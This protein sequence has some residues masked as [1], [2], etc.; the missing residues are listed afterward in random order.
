[1]NKENI[2][3]LAGIIERAELPELK[4]NMNVVY[5]S[6]ERA[7]CGTA[8][9]IIGWIAVLTKGKAHAEETAGVTLQDEADEFM[10]EHFS[11]LFYPT[12]LVG[13]WSQIT[14]AHTATVLRH[15]A[16]TGEV[17]W[18]K[19]IDLSPELAKYEGNRY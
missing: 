9:C 19:F 6:D 8:G 10:G 4:L 12:E 1:M 2:T 11:G 5:Q 16:E 18:R 14:P 13:D 17:D 7:G 15:L 3:R